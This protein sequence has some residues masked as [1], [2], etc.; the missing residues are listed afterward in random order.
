[1]ERKFY[2]TYFSRL[3]AF[4]PSKAFKLHNPLTTCRTSRAVSVKVLEV[5]ST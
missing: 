4:K 3:P 5:F 1:M 2:V